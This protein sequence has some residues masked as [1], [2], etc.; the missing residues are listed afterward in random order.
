MYPPKQKGKKKQ[1]GEQK[2][3]KIYN[4]SEDTGHQT[5]KDN[6]PWENEKQTI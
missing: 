4:N 1:E 6:D 2:G 5:V 3:Q